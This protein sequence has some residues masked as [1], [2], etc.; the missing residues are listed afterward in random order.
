MKTLFCLFAMMVFLTRVDASYLVLNGDLTWNITD[1]QCSFRLKGKLQNLGVNT[2]SLRLALWATRTPYPAS[3]TLVAE[4]PLGQ[5]GSGYQF[6]SFTFKTKA[7]LPPENGVIYYTITVMEFTAAGWRNQIMV[8]TGTR[9]MYQG[10]FADQE[11]WRLPR[12]RLVE[13][14]AE[15]EEGSR[16]VLREQAM[17]NLNRFPVGWRQLYKLDVLNDQEIDYQNRN[18]DETVDFE[19]KVLRRRY[20]RK[21][22]DVGFLELQYTGR[23]N[24]KFSQN[25][26]LFF[27]GPNRGTYKSVI[28]GSLW[29][30]STNPWRTWGTF[31]LK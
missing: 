12:R 4:F 26:Y 11:K 30:D 1:P 21:R 13:P 15:L 16:L 10:Q 17:S 27:K 29:G 20:L 2:G 3:G 18:L 31:K 9:T 6:D 5:L 19:Y 24:I 14:P 23:S 7:T 22:A 25:V 28:K 8:P